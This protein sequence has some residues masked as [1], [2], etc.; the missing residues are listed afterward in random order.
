MCIWLD[1]PSFDKIGSPRCSCSRSS[2]RCSH[3]ST[4]DRTS[5]RC[6][7]CHRTGQ[8]RT[9][10]PLSRFGSS[11]CFMSEI[12]PRN[13]LLVLPVRPVSNIMEMLSWSRHSEGK[14]SEPPFAEGK[15]PP[16]LP[17]LLTQRLQAVC[18]KGSPRCSCS[19]SSQRCT[20]C[21]TTD[22]TSH[23][24]CGRH[25]TGQLSHPPR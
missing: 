23:R 18:K 10:N 22:R 5:H 20:H 2:Q 17:S 13:C 7:G 19:R 25:R 9:P 14:P 15:S 11:I 21:R 8:G 3:S 1:A 6:C 4:T 24:S 12:L 16:F